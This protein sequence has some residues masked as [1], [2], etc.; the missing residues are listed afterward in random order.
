MVSEQLCDMGIAEYRKK[1]YWELFSTELCKRF[2]NCNEEV[3]KILEEGFEIRSNNI[4]LEDEEDAAKEEEIEVQIFIQQPTI[5]AIASPSM[6]LSI[7]ATATSF[8]TA[9]LFCISDISQS[10]TSLALLTYPYWKISNGYLVFLF[11]PLPKVFSA[12]F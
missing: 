2:S 12:S 7:T 8:A 1:I 5:S 9:L 11:L 10:Q 6:P 3:E 4:I